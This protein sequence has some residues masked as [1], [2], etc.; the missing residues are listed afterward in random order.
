MLGLGLGL[1]CPLCV[2][3]RP[4]LREGDG[5]RA[6]ARS[7]FRAALGVSQQKRS[8]PVPLVPSVLAPECKAQKW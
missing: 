3:T 1:G 5:R 7:E 2:P 4:D 8:C 6:A